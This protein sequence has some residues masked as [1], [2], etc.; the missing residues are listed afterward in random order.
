MYSTVPQCDAINAIPPP[1]LVECASPL[2]SAFVDSCIQKV[3]AQ[4]TVPE[5]TAHLGAQWRMA[6][7]GDATDGRL[8]L[9]AECVTAPHRDPVIN[10]A[11]TSFSQSEHES[12]VLESA[13]FLSHTN[14]SPPWCCSP[15]AS[16]CSSRRTET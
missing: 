13:S 9:T 7:E 1:L 8:M 14:L 4:P 11:V 2:Y 5:F 3:D 10:F 6:A 12:D 15:T 16:T